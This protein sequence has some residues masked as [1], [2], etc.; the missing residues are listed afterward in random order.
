MPR[1]RQAPRRPTLPDS[2]ARSSRPA[3]TNQVCTG[4]S[5]N[6][7]TPPPCP[8]RIRPLWEFLLRHFVN[9]QNWKMSLQQFDRAPSD[10]E[11]L[12]CVAQLILNQFLPPL[13]L[14]DFKHDAI[15]R[16]NRFSK[17]QQTLHFLDAQIPHILLGPYKSVVRLF[18]SAGTKT[19]DSVVVFPPLPQP[20]G[21]CV[22][23]LEIHTP[24][25]G[26]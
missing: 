22:I 16:A 14:L 12:L 17:L 3:L 6:P 8:R 11:K 24:Y 25:T 26:R 21:V 7:P 5:R 19:L 4:Y 9:P 10:R 13:M 1:P 18:S 2:H 20:R 15:G 23:I